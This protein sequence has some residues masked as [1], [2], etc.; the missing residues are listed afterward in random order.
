MEGVEQMNIIKLLTTLRYIIRMRR[1]LI[2]KRVRW[3][4]FRYEHDCGAEL[5]KNPQLVYVDCTLFTYCPICKARV[6]FRLHQSMM[7]SGKEVKTSDVKKK[8]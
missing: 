6:S 5:Q 3:L 7:A 1:L 2:I 4:I 8:K